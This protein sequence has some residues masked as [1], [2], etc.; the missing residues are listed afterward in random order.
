MTP[1]LQGFVIGVLLT[2]A[3][4]VVAVAITGRHV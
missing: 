2:L 3:A 4:A 1:I